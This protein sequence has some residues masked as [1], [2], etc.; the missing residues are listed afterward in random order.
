MKTEKPTPHRLK[1]ESQKGKSFNSKDFTAAAVLIGGVI[2][3]GA[4]TSLGAIG[5]LYVAILE[6]NFQLPM[7][8]VMSMA[9]IAFLKSVAPVGLIAICCAAISSLIQSRGVLA[10]DRNG[11][12]F[13]KLNPVSGFKN[14]VSLRVVKDLT[15]TLLYLLFASG[16]AVVLWK[17]FAP[18]IF[19]LV[20]A[21]PHQAGPAWAH[22]LVRYGALLLAALAPVYGLSMFLDYRLHIRD[23][24]MDK[25]EI[26]QENKDLQGNQE[27]KGK[28]R[29]LGAELSAQVQS[30]VA[31]SSMILANPT[32]IA[33]GIFI[34][35]GDIRHPFVSVR[36]KGPRARAAIALAEKSGIPVVRD[37]KVARAV[38]ATSKRYRFV[39]PSAL[40]DVMRVLQW[41]Q[42]VEKSA[43]EMAGEDILPRLH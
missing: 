33:V 10:T 7:K 30:D 24:R 2:A 39:D 26:K 16:A 9:V 20:H 32:H 38:Y 27:I 14:L 5:Q 3:L 1:K 40:E 21:H 37:I 12:D 4:W 11:F 15:R 6:S 17:T 43:A 8:A 28:R 23:M 13:T 35:Q 41:L 19:S 42:D 34:Y 31:G 29:E 22:L 36:E 25:S 18:S